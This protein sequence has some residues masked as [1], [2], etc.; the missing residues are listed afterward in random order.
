LRWTIRHNTRYRYS[1]P[2]FLEPHSLRLTPATDAAQR[3]LNFQLWLTPEPAGRTANVDVEDN[4]VVRVWFEAA[5]SELSIAVT[6]TVETLRSNPFDYLWDGP[7]TMPLRYGEEARE[8]LLPYGSDRL[9]GEVGELADTAA[10]EAGGDAQAFPALLAAS[11][12]TACRQVHREEGKPRPAAETLKLGEG[13]CRDLAQL[14]L[15]AARSKGFAARFVSGYIADHEED[16]RE[17]HAWVELYLPGGGWRGF[18][19]TTG[20]ATAGQHIV[21]ARSA[22][23]AMAAPLSGSFRGSATATLETEVNIQPAS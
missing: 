17:L 22:S 2:V 19:P 21:L 18:D 9:L 1:A 6:S 14:F 11:I 16:S 5:T 4:G 10:V 3:L 15:E 20:L 8:L 23:A 12:H 7:K 13:S